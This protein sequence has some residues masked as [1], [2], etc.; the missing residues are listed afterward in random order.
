LFAH[1]FAAFLI[2]AERVQGVRREGYVCTFPRQVLNEQPVG[3]VK[4]HLSAL[5]P[6]PRHI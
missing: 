5:S 3:P 2:V 4:L 1:L 6:W